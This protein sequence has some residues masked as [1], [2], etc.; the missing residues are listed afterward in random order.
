MG[1]RTLRLQLTCCS[2]RFCL[3]GRDA[4]GGDLD[5][6]C[7]P[8][9]CVLLSCPRPRSSLA[10]RFHGTA[11]FDVRLS[12]YLRPRLVRITLGWLISPTAKIRA[13]TACNVGG[14]SISLFFDRRLGH[15]R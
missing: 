12:H 14:T 4:S 15:R 10:L 1:L 11:R 7:R 13:A 6:P 3:S 5:P 2:R 8:T 9:A